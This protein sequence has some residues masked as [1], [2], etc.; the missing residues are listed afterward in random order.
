MGTFIAQLKSCLLDC[1]DWESSCFAMHWFS[2][3][4]WCDT[5]SASSKKYISTY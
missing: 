2:I 3:V 5:L 1:F 4:G